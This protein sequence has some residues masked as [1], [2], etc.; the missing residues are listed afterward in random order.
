[1][2]IIWLAVLISFAINAPAAEH[3][4]GQQ[5]RV[6][7]LASPK[8]VSRL[9]IKKPGVYENYQVDAQGKGGNIVKIT[10]D[11]VTLR[12]CEIS[13]GTGNGIGVFGTR[14]V[15]ENCRIHHLLSGTFKEQH[16]AHGITGHWGDVT[17][18]N[19]D[20]SFT[21]GDCIQF[22][23]ERASQG[24]VVIE[25]CHLWTGPLAADS[26][27]FKAGERPGENAV[28]TKTKDGAERSKLVVRNCYLHGWNQPAQ[29][30]NMAALNL[31][32]NID[33]QIAHCVFSDN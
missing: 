26:A 12:N 9:E 20:I 28:D 14:V 8:T 10:A 4:V 1:M 13:N 5:G 17:I 19:C 7:S 23:P 15:I 11:D 31:K 29:I 32:E 16:D 25:N 24:S 21:S 27:G 30:G 33:A 18:R 6:G 22:D 3:P 2:K